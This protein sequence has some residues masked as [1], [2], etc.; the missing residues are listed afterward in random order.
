MMPEEKPAA[1]SGEPIMQFFRFDHLPEKLQAVSRPGELA[2]RVMHLPRNPERSVALRKLLEAKDAAV[3]ALI[4]LAV[5]LF[6]LP[7][8]ADAS[9]APSSGMLSALL[10]MVLSAK[11]LGVMASIVAVVLGAVG[12]NNEVRRRRLALGAYYAFHI[13]EDLAAETEGEDALDKVAAGLKALDSYFLANGFRP[14]KP[15]EQEV[16]K[17][18][19]T[20][21]NGAQQA[22]IKV[23]AAAIDA[24]KGTPAPAVP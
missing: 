15:G 6:A 5:V 2:D 11:G 1:P 12:I 13:V 9:P 21:L 16:A 8:L 10:G 22:A 24:A 3:R 7:A 18:Q 4:A 14:P 23:Q 20:A 17:L 19:F